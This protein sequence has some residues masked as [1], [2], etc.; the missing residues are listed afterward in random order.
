MSLGKAIQ[1]A[2]KKVGMTQVELG[3]AIGVSG[4]MIG[5]W[6][7]DLRN[8][9]PETI[10]R[11]ANALGDSF[12]ESLFADPEDYEFIR[13]LGLIDPEKRKHNLGA[14]KP[15]PDKFTALNDILNYAGYNLQLI[16]EDYCFTGADGAYTLTEKQVEELFC[17]IVKY[18]D[19]L[20]SNLEK[21][22][23]QKVFSSISHTK[24]TEP[25]E[26]LSADGEYTDTT[27]KE[28]PLEGV[29]TPTD[30]K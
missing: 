17:E 26:T 2:R 25:P 4:S 12:T 27:Q 23:T 28:K 14:I 8:P 24:R 29:E 1:T 30:G 10:G 20:C 3:E 11:I 13:W 9:K 21:Q 7:N 19:Y 16:H 5:Q 18:A 22:E 6:E 15:L